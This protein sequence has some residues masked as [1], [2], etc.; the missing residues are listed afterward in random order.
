M[1]FPAK[2]A[3]P[4]SK[5]IMCCYLSDL[6]LRASCSCEQ[7]S[8]VLVNKKLARSS[9]DNS[10]QHVFSSKTYLKM[11]LYWRYSLITLFIHRNVVCFLCVIQ[12]SIKYINSICSNNNDY[13][14]V[15]LFF[16]YISCL[17]GILALKRNNLTCK[18]PI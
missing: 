5:S 8:T 12:F 6:C 11:S 18:I 13:S 16:H 14:M 15:A 17:A 4:L 1:W 2:N 9:S 7:R 10:E 3:I